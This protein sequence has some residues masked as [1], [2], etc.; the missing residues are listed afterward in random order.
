MSNYKHGNWYCKPANEAEALEIVERA[1]ASGAKNKAGWKGNSTR[2]TYGVINGRVDFGVLD[3]T[4]YTITQLRNKFPLPGEWVTEWDG[5]WLP[6]VGTVCEAIYD[7]VWHRCEILKYKVN[8]L[9]KTVAACD[10]IFDLAWSA[11]FRP[12]RTERDQ[13]VA[14]AQKHCTEFSSNQLGKLYDALK[15]G[16]L[17]APE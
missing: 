4:E 6:P 8:N 17:K 2:N 9:G 1:V 10:F 15:S 14:E 12:L 11:V 3:G 13:W 16:T 5:E 7:K